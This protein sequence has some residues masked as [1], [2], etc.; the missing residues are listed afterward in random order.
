MIPKLIEIPLP[1]GSLPIYSFGVS[2]VLC[3]L[4]AWR[5]LEQQL[6]RAG[7][8]PELAER[9]I[10]W[11]AIGGIV[12][13]RIC[14]ILTFP[15]EF[16]AAPIAT[17]FGGAGFVFYGGFIGGAFAVWLL[18][19][20]EKKSFLKMSDLTAPSLAVGYAVGRIG[21]QLS[22]DGDYGKES[23]LPWA[24]SYAHGVVPTPPGVLVHPTP[25]Y[26]TIVSLAIAMLLLWLGKKSFRFLAV[27]GAL[28]GV[29]LMLSAVARF[30]VEFIRIEP[31]V[32]LSLTEAQVIGLI[33]F[34][35][36]LWL[37]ARRPSV[38]N[39]G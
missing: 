16:L 26:E 32:L 38:V 11:A 12:G 37:F 36:G 2:M 34:G 5:C 20:K 9:M 7:E 28:F 13:A 24:M 8:P 39:A 27:N 1:F 25:V 29:Y 6:K 22:G 21:C 35:I 19:R 31:I 33:M 23:S 17:A 15:H 4:A 14:Y 3:F 18:L 30:L 10:T